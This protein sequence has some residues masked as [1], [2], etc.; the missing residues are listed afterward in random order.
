[1]ILEFLLDS[2]KPM[3]FNTIFAFARLFGNNLWRQERH[4]YNYH[5]SFGHVFAVPKYKISPKKKREREREK[6]K[7]VGM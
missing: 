3:S 1:M 4:M 2:H 5:I 6:K 7:N